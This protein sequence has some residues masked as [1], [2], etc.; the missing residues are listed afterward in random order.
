MAITPDDIRNQGFKKSINGYNT[1]AVELYL[2]EIAGEIEDMEEKL[3]ASKAK[4]SGLEAQLVNY[5]TMEKIMQ[6]TLM[7]AQET[8][9]KSIENARKEAELIL[10]QAQMQASQIIEKARTDLTGMKEQIAILLSKKDSIIS[11][12]KMLLQSELD[13]INSAQQDPEFKLD[14]PKP[15][16]ADAHGRSTEIE[17]IIK[18]LG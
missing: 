5:K 8:S 11:R 3:A 7:S 15:P 13:T 12:L 10:H 2:N 18:S 9:G 4:I 1:Q 17:D 16:P 14:V 6:Q